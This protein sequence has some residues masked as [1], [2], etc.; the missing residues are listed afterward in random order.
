[1]FCCCCCF[2]LFLFVCLFVCCCCFF[3]V[4]FFWGG[5][6]GGVFIGGVLCVFLCVCVFFLLFFCF[7]NAKLMKPRLFFNSFTVNRMSKNFL[8]GLSMFISPLLSAA[9]TDETLCIFQ[10]LGDLLKCQK[11]Y[12]EEAGRPVHDEHLFI[13]THQGK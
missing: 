5:G 11:P 7:G 4:F 3:V 9:F 8:F 6:V 12:S 13:V 1:M 10:Q 2:C